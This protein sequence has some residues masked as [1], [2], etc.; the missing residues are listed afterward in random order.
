LNWTLENYSANIFARYTDSYKDDQNAFIE[1]D[2]HL[3]WDAQLNID[4]G[5]IFETDGGYV[6]SFGGV[7]LTDEN[8]PQV[9]TNGGFDSKV[10]D[11]RGR[12]VY[13][14]LAVEF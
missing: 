11:P 4:L 13:A 7:N 9:F 2:S 12:Q 1:I 5:G 3:T 8:P 6:L 14:R 10:H